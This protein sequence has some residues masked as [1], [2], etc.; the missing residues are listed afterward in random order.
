MVTKFEVG[1]YYRCNRTEPNTLWDGCDGRGGAM[2][3]VLDGK[4]RKCLK[5]TE[6]GYADLEGVSRKTCTN[7]CGMWLWNLPDFDEVKVEVYNPDHDGKRF[8][9]IKAVNDESSKNNEGK[10]GQYIA[11]SAGKVLWQDGHEETLRFGSIIEVLEDAEK[12]EPEKHCSCEGCA[13]AGAPHTHPVCHKCITAP[14]REMTEWT[15]ASKPPSPFPPEYGDMTGWR[16]LNE[17]EIIGENDEHFWDTWGSTANKGLSVKE[18]KAKYEG[19]VK[20]YRRKIEEKPK[21][22]TFSNCTVITTHVPQVYPELVPIESVPVGTR[23]RLVQ[24]NLSD[25]YRTRMPELLGQTGETDAGCF[26]NTLLIKFDSDVTR[27]IDYGALVEVLEDRKVLVHDSGWYGAK[28]F[29]KAPSTDFTYVSPERNSERR[30][31]LLREIK[32]DE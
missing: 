18:A 13:Y 31:K 24:F 8:L 7:N 21:G 20:A 29:D 4:P 19:R 11:G 6:Y 2:M 12:P 3:V 32:V 14:E 23:V 15:A 27:H 26:N 1:K 16:L 9:L 30:R 25:A 10:I 22:M 28:G 5:S 17:E